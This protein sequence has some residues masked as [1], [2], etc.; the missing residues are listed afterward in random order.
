MPNAQR[1][2]LEMPLLWLV[3]H[4]QEGKEGHETNGDSNDMLL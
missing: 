2:T 1:K 4:D 3:P